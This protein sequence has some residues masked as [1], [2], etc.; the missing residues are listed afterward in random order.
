MR[1][2]TTTIGRAEGCVP[3]GGRRRGGWGRVNATK[4]D[5]K[6]KTCKCD[7]MT[8]APQCTPTVLCPGCIFGA[9][10]TWGALTCVK[11]DACQLHACSGSVIGAVCLLC[12]LHLEQQLTICN[13]LRPEIMR[14]KLYKTLKTWLMSVLP[15]NC[16][17]LCRSR[18][19]ILVRELPSCRLRA[20]DE[21]YSK[22]DMIDCIVASCSILTPCKYRDRWYTDCIYV[23]K[24]SFDHVLVTKT[25]TCPPTMV[26]ARSL[27]R[28]GRALKSPFL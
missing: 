7:K 4:M 21:W 23:P 2:H 10:Y 13:K 5:E 18:L 22:E 12:H 1:Y 8:P 6:N 25:V 28:E 20:F 15:E 16:H 19:C 26:G 11:T 24:S 3:R 17:R 14:F 9:W 27:F